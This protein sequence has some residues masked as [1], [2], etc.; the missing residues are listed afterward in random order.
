M[1]LL[2]DRN[3]RGHYSMSQTS[4]Q[5]R[6]R[7]AH[8]QQLPKVQARMRRVCSSRHLQAARRRLCQLHA[9]ALCQWPVAAHVD[10]HESAHGCQTCARVSAT[11]TGGLTPALSGASADSTALRWSA[12]LPS[13]GC[14]IVGDRAVGEHDSFSLSSKPDVCTR[15]GGGA[16][17]SRERLGVAVAGRTWPAAAS[18]IADS[19]PSHQH[20]ITV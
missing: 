14:G 19:F 15:P 17:V 9:V 11:E 1:V 3:P 4:H 16:A 18:S 6:R 7:K 10:V 8:L 20:L 12:L 5:M 2:V 13:T